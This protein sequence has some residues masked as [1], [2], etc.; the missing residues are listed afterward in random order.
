MRLHLS[1]AKRYLDEAGHLNAS[2]AGLLVQLQCP[3]D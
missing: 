3:E 2:G 1:R